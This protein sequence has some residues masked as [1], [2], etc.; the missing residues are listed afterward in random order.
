ML[1][2][3]SG[4]RVDCDSLDRICFRY[5][6]QFFGALAIEFYVFVDRSDATKVIQP[7]TAHT[8]FTDGRLYA[9]MRLMLER[10]FLRDIAKIK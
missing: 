2:I 8:R 1:K 5:E 4:T 7:R 10:R 3:L 9:D 6:V